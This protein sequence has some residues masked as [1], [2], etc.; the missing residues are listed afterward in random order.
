MDEKEAPAVPSRPRVPGV[1]TRRD[2]EERER[3]T[4]RRLRWRQRSRRPLRY[5]NGG[6]ATLLV[7]APVAL[8]VSAARLSAGQQGHGWIQQLALPCAVTGVALAAVEFLYLRR[9]VDE[10]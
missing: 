1:L 7:L 6:Q 2:V 9:P 10:R 5:M 4:R 8:L 3:L